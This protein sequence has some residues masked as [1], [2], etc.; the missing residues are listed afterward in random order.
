[1]AAGDGPRQGPNA[2]LVSLQD[3]TAHLNCQRHH[4]QSA[5]EG[6]IVANVAMKK[7][8]TACG[9]VSSPACIPRSVVV[10]ATLTKGMLMV[11]GQPHSALPPATGVHGRTAC[12][13]LRHWRKVSQARAVRAGCNRQADPS[14]TGA[15]CSTP[16]C[17]PRIST[18]CF[19]R[20][21]LACLARQ[22]CE[23]R[24]LASGLDSRSGASAARR[25]GR[26]RWRRQLS[27]EHAASGMQ[28]S[29]G[30]SIGA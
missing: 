4:M 23:L 14:R 25:W 8:L 27:S 20:R 26:P 16:T 1:M 6:L 3:Y 11:Y 17:N 24:H 9:A 7:T 29:I 5:L 19:A 2:L 28:P 22:R 12:R 15:G 13:Q 21:K 30:C 10:T 18:I